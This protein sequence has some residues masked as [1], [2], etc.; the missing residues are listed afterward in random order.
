MRSMDLLNCLTITLCECFRSSYL[1]VADGGVG[2]VEPLLR[3]G[4]RGVSV[5][6]DEAHRDR[7]RA[8]STKTRSSPT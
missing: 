8:V 7:R 6:S 1:D 2:V 3:R 5:Q 4:A